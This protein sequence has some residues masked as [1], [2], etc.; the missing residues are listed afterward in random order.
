MIGMSTLGTLQSPKTMVRRCGR[1][2]SK[3]V[4][5]TSA[6]FVGLLAAVTQA[7]AATEFE[8]YL[9][10]GYGEVAWF[11]GAKLDNPEAAKLFKARANEAARGQTVLPATIDSA[12]VI[13]DAMRAEAIEA[14][15]D[16][17][18]AF[19][20]GLRESDPQIAAVAQVNYDCWVAQ[21]PTVAGLPDSSDCRALF[22]QAMESA[23]VQVAA[24]DADRSHDGADEPQIATVPPLNCGGLV[25]CTD[26]LAT[27][28]QIASVPDDNDPGADDGDNDGGG[29]GT[30]PGNDDDDDGSGGGGGG[31]SSD[32]DDDD[33]SNGGGN[34][35]GGALV[36]IGI[37]SGNGTGNGSLVGVGIATPTRVR[38]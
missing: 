2:V 14:H 33:G 27:A 11:A 5:A 22:Y 37:D 7:Q 1:R 8:T 24:M 9:A 10:Q 26:P 28:A 38:A 4:L 30:D 6:A 12:S 29:G 31:G 3:S 34:N 20:D 15:S 23:G 21:F 16:L 36:G 35:G 32:N 18:A 19:D 13:P 17:M 25:P